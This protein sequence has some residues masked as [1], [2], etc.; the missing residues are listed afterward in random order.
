MICCVWRV[1]R[2]S[3]QDVLIENKCDRWLL[4]YDWLFY[5][6]DIY[7]FVIQ[8]EKAFL[9]DAQSCCC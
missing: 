3:H 2:L 8:D 1:E 7:S 6:V 9:L 4:R 5:S